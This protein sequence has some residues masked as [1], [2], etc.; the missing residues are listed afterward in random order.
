LQNIGCGAVVAFGVLWFVINAIVN[1]SGIAFFIACLIVIGGAIWLFS[2]IE[3]T[4]QGTRTAVSKANS[5]YPQRLKELSES[6]PIRSNVPMALK[7]GEEF[8]YRLES[9]SLIESRSNGS[10]YQG[11]SRGVSVRVMKGVSYRVGASKGQFVK[12]PES[13]QVIDTGAATFTNQRILFV[14]MKA[15]R[16]WDFAKLTD[17]SQ[18]EGRETI[19]ISVSNRQKPSGLQAPSLSL[20]QPGILADIALEYS[21]NGVEAAKLRCLQEAGLKQQSL[22]PSDKPTTLDS[23]PVAAYVQPPNSSEAPTTASLR[24]DELRFT[25]GDEIIEVVGESFYA[26][27]FEQIRTSQN[28]EYGDEKNFVLDLVA[29]PFNKFSQNGH[30]VGVQFEGKVIG[31]ISEDENTELFEILKE[32]NG[33]G[34]CD[35]CIYF[36]PVADVMKNSVTLFVTEELT[37]N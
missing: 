25:Y 21:Q 14:G 24:N 8:L 12:N 26:D 23:T 28:I 7:K 15:S 20:I 19:M 2:W 3:K 17:L 33:R 13:L 22:E 32:F 27:A 35:G 11:G 16:E 36:A 9:I 6:L 4:K 10:T 5:Y 30:A 29:E 1:N 31:H 34:K 18:T 37:H